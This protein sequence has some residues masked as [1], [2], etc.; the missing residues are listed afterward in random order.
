MESNYFEKFEKRF[1]ELAKEGYA[2]SLGRRYWLSL[3]EILPDLPE[4]TFCSHDFVVR[5]H[6][7]QGEEYTFKSM[8]FRMYD[9]DTG[10][11]SDWEYK[12]IE[13]SPAYKSVILKGKEIYVFNALLQDGLYYPH[14]MMYSP[15][16]LSHKFVYTD[17][18]GQEQDLFPTREDG[19]RGR[20]SQSARNTA[21]FHA[22][23][24]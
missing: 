13:Y 17:D 8:S 19:G 18:K 16:M 20:P 1:N 4:D 11:W 6:E 10:K 22:S 14:L 15:E 21:R 5:F 24:R 9:E 2:L 7:Q 12:D 3:K 23:L